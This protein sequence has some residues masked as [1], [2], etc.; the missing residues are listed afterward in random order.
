PQA[1]RREALRCFGDVER[2][3]GVVRAIDHHKERAMRRVEWWDELG[4]D[5]RFAIRGLRRQPGFATAAVLTLALGIGAT[6]AILS[7]VDGVVPRPF[8]Y[9][10][11]AGVVRLWEPGV[12]GRRAAGA[13]LP[14][15]L[16]NFAD[17]RDRATT[18]EHM[19]AFR[20]WSAT[21]VEGTEPEILSGAR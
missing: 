8:P 6:T 19:A 1:A 15:S 20:Q 17:L 12:P 5:V 7:A 16:A 13:D 18:F 10:N 14:F 4:Q 9:P 3:R 11:A 21:L 2:I